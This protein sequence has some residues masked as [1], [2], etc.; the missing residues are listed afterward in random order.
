ME[1]SL[2][3][4]FVCATGEKTSITISDVKSELTNPEVVSLMDTIIEND[5]FATSKGSL[6]S[7]YSAQVIQRQVTKWELQ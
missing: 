1:Y 5:I 2:Q 7:K 4:V 6:T 3:M